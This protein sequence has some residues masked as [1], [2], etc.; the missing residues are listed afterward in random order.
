MNAPARDVLPPDLSRAALAALAA[1]LERLAGGPVDGALDFVALEPMAR[2]AG[3]APRLLVAAS[4]RGCFPPILRVSERLHLLRRTDFATWAA[5]A[6]LGP[7]RAAAVA[8]HLD[9]TPAEPFAAAEPPP[10]PQRRRRR[11]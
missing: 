11:P 5:R 8:A 1:E 9:D 3:V 4:R 6:E 7:A 2:R 10:A